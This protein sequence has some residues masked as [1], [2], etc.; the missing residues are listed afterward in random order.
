MNVYSY[1]TRESKVLI[2]I[3]YKDCVSPHYLSKGWKDKG[4]VIPPVQN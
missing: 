4:L 1:F 2:A 3:S